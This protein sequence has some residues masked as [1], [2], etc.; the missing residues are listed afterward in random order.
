MQLV[1]NLRKRLLKFV[2]WL[3]AKAKDH[4]DWD[5]NDPECIASANEVT[6]IKNDLRKQIS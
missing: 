1:N 2:L 5:N 3:E 6:K 4:P